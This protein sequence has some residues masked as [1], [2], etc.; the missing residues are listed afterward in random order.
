MGNKILE[1]GENEKVW[2]CE[3]CGEHNKLNIEKEEIP[4]GEDMIYIVQSAN[5][6]NE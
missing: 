3:F 4:A 1:I 5:Q 6:Q 2:I